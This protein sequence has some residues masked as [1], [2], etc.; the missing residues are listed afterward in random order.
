[1]IREALSRLSEPDYLHCVQKLGN[2]CR[3]GG[4]VSIAHMLP[5]GRSG[6]PVPIVARDL[7][8]LQKSV[9]AMGLIRPSVQ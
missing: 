6:V 2:V 4:A 9:P 5:V 8:L 7:S 1:M 3:R